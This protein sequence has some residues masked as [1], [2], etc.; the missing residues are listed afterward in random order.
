MPGLGPFFALDVHPAGA[1]PV[2]PW[3][4]FAE[5]LS[6]DGGRLRARA[7]AVREALA[8]RGGCPVDAVP[9]RVAVSV[10]HLGLAARLIAPAVAAAALGGLSRLGLAAGGL[11]WQDQLGRPVPLS[12]P[13]AGGGGPPPG[14]IDDLVA[15]LT[16]AA[17]ALVP[18][19]P[20]VLWGNVASAISG[21]AGQIAGQRPEL[22]PAA[23]AAARELAGHPSLSRERAEP[24][25]GFRRSS[26][27]LIY[28]LSPGPARAICGDCVLGVAAP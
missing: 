4:A 3:L 16:E 12:V 27:C 2:P 6:A 11:W 28:Q 26:C 23:W 10:M 9:L 8:G 18:V 5:L 22:A 13:V 21:A 15:P 25:P 1:D 7:E 19:S 14:V 20:R 17:G 24:G